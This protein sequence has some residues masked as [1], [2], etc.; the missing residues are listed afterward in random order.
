MR[1]LF[2]TLPFTGHFHPLVPVAR[3]ARAAGHEVA[4]A[5]PAPFVARVEA[6][7][8][9]AF[10][11][12]FDDGGHPFPALFPGTLRY[13]VEERAPWVIEH[14]F[15]G[16]YG[17]VM[18]TDLLSLCRDWQ[19]DVLVRDTSEFGGCVAAETLGLPHASVRTGA[20]TATY[21]LRHR[22]TEALAPLRERAGLDPDPDSAMPFRYL[23]LATEPAGFARPGDMPA[24]TA[25]L[26]RPESAETGNDPPPAWVA[27]LPDRPTIYATLGTQFGA[28]PAGR[29]TF[30]AI[31][32]ALRDE[33]CNLIVTVGRDVDPAD[34]GPQPEHVHIE[35][36]IPQGQLL[37][38]CDL[39]VNHGGFSTIT[40]ALSAGLPM[41]IV[42]IGADQPLNAACCTVLGVGR[43]VGPEERTPEAIR[44]AVRAVLAD[45]S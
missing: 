11:A 31:L 42:P 10:G 29:A 20:W 18:A 37:P 9:H 26:V 8:F 30:A 13:R 34:F 28:L 6:A 27:G 21:A 38:R 19:P 33:P 17:A 22:W 5:C 45:P 2:T 7:G 24:P 15:I 25:H 3:A 35:R 14:G 43:V 40:G 44:E 32:A 1:V 39:V 41:V 36:Y 16:L 23:H 12:G 4:F